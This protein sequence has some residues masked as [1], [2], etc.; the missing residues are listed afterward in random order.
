MS[1]YFL[2]SGLQLVSRV[3]ISLVILLRT[4]QARTAFG[5]SNVTMDLEVAATSCATFWEGNVVNNSEG[6]FS[7]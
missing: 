2:H 4:Q 1:V 6:S 3:L 5:Q 7:F